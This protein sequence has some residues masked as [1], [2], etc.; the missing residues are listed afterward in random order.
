ML[1]KAVQRPKEFPAKS[2]THEVAAWCEF[3]CQLFC[4]FALEELMVFNRATGLTRI[5]SL[6][7]FIPSINLTNTHTNCTSAHPI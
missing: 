1:E 3:R 6:L 2:V 5:L 4:F 7:R